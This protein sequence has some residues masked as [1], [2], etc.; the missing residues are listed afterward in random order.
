[1]PIYNGEKTIRRALDSIFNQTYG[2]FVVVV[3]VE[4]GCTDDTLAICHEYE[5]KDSRIR[6]LQ[7][8]TNL[9]VSKSLNK[10]LQACIGKYVVRMDADDFS[11]SDRLEKQVSFMETH[12][13]ID[14][15]GTRCKTIGEAGIS[16]SK[17]KLDNDE[18]RAQLLFRTPFTHPTIMMRLD[19]LRNNKLEYP[20]CLVEDYAL[21]AKMF[22][23][24][25]FANLCDYSLEYYH[26]NNNTTT[27]KKK[28]IHQ[29]SA[30][31]SKSLISGVFG[32]D[33]SAYDSSYFGWRPERV[34][35]SD[36]IKYLNNGAE[37]L[38]K[39][40]QINASTLKV[41]APSLER[42]LIAQWKQTKR[43]VGLP[44]LSVTFDL[45]NTESLKEAMN[46]SNDSIYMDQNMSLSVLNQLDILFG[47]FIPAHSEI[48]LF[49]AGVY[50]RAFR[51]FLHNCGIQ[52][53]GYVVSN[54]Y[55]EAKDIIDLKEF[56]RIY[57]TNATGL[58][59]TI[60]GMHYDE[61]LP[62]LNFCKDNLYIV[63][64]HLKK[65]AAKHL[66]TTDA[67]NFT[68]DI[69]RH[70]NLNC[71][72]C[73]TGAPLASEI[74]CSVENLTRDYVLL[75]SLFKNFTQVNLSGGETLL[76]PDFL[77]IVELTRAM[78]PNAL[79]S[80]STNGLLFDLS[81]SD[82]WKRLERVNA[83]IYWTQYPV[84]YP[85]GK[86]DL[87]K[88]AEY[89]DIRI[90]CDTGGNREKESWYLPFSEKANAKKYEYLLCGFYKDH[91]DHFCLRDS[92]IYL[93]AA[94]Y[95]ALECNEYFNKNLPINEGSEFLE[96]NNIRS[97]KE[98]V[99]FLNSVPKLCSFCAIRE[100]RS[101]REWLPSKKKVGEWII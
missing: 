20:I 29:E 96:L 88:I 26:H 90:L 66:S 13:E 32:I 7:N 79:L 59:L 10:G 68:V 30:E 91:G 81:N 82:F 31:I 58:I 25:K 50:G 99:T 33:T 84:D 17:N 89:Y 80:I 92:K 4:D 94:P 78:F 14:I 42:E 39:I 52:V 15:L 24:A 8:D 27:V 19:Y 69:V 60:D 48:W 56:R 83:V 57:T 44:N 93:C 23:T 63:D 2:N 35:E 67:L 16:L 85:F 45:A 38:R 40:K 65:Q 41:D 46:N 71:F 55:N 73:G 37:L 97:D 12:P 95:R 11:L 70:C 86:E 47:K 22:S 5:K 9:G 6:I 1:M 87:L 98:L 62:N 61:V 75:N 49:G 74:Y 100:R 77:E 43:I 101:M 53:K 76:H 72:S 51:H 21:F 64:E 3:V 18:I 34:D 36:P 54:L 28:A